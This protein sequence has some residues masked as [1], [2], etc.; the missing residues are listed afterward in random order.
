MDNKFDI[1]F[2]FEHNLIN[3]LNTYIKLIELY[4]LLDSEHQKSILLDFAQV[5]FLSANL[6]AVLGCCVENTIVQRGHR[7]AINKIHPKIK[8]VMRRNGF[9]KYF[10]WD[11]LEDIYHSTM[12]YAS[13]KATTNNLVFFE[14]Y[15]LLNIFSRKEL[16]IMDSSYKNC[17]IDN[18][19]E[20]FNNVIDH[21]ES[22]YVYVC[23][24]YFP[25]SSNLSFSIVDQGKTIKRN[26]MEYLSENADSPPDNT[27]KWAILPGNSTKMEYAPGGLGFST[28]LEFLKQNRGSFILISDNEVYE[29]Q[30][31]K[32]RFKKL[33]LAF[34][35]T[36]V[37]ITI[38]LK[39]EHFYLLNND[40]LITF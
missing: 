38:N 22:P 10:A 8:D 19:L 6:L 15:L 28:L 9:N 35:G 16:P 36:I 39:D 5:N 11:D 30:S 24:Q 12:D 18:F 2:P 31:G 20:M 4:H 27:L 14:R 23:G 13:F 21:A 1:T 7:V 32:E 34:P 40:N 25:K 29:I 26:V 33:S 37:T 3:D 17:I